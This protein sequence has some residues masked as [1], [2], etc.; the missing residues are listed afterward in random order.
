[1][2]LAVDCP[3]NFKDSR[4]M[5]AIDMTKVTRAEKSGKFDGLYHADAW[6]LKLRIEARNDIAGHRR[7]TRWFWNTFRKSLNNPNY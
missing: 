5:Q 1:M 2:R 7:L 4:L 6:E 3:L